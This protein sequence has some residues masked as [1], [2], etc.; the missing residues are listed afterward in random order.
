MANRRQ[1]SKVPHIL[2]VVGETGID[3][4]YNIDNV[5]ETVEPLGLHG[6]VA[7]GG[8]RD[9]KVRYRDS[10]RSPVKKSQ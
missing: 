4:T 8:F 9:Q 3:R 1:P 6:S 10:S 2:S 7:S 5:S